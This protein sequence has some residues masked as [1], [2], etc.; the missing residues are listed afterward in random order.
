MPKVTLLNVHRVGAQS[1]YAYLEFHV[2]DTNRE[3]VVPILGDMETEEALDLLADE[4]EKR[5]SGWG[6]AAY[7]AGREQLSEKDFAAERAELER[8][9]RR[10]KKWKGPVPEA[11][12]FPDFIESRQ[13]NMLVTDREGNPYCYKL[14][15]KVIQDILPPPEEGKTAIR[16]K[17]G[18]SWLTKKRPIRPELSRAG[19]LKAKREPGGWRIK[20]PDRKVSERTLNIEDTRWN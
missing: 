19:A 6:M 1:P 17:Q 14:R 9:V 10:R 3:Y 20:D 13:W 18:I 11:V 2:P 8:Q 16:D 7:D 12:V 15:D 4:V 5:H